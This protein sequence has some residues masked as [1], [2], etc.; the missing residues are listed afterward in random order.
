MTIAVDLGCKATKQN[1]Q[2]NKQQTQL[3]TPASSKS[4]DAPEACPSLR[5]SQSQSMDV[6]ESLF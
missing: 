2:T 6:D 4:L 1:K 5:Y 3:I